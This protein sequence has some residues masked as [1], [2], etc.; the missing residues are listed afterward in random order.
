MSPVD[1]DPAA[2]DLDLSHVALSCCSICF[3]NG[4]KYNFEF[5]FFWGPFAP[6]TN[7]YQLRP[8]YKVFS[9]RNDLTYE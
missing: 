5:L 2:C 6:F 8:E 4:F 9:K 3:T 7:S 1:L